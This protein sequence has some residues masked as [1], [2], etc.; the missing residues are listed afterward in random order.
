MGPLEYAVFITTS[1]LRL[2]AAGW[3]LDVIF[4]GNFEVGFRT[5]WQA[6]ALYVLAEFAI[7]VLHNYVRYR[8]I[9]VQSQLRRAAKEV[10]ERELREARLQQLQAQRQASE[11]YFDS[12]DM[13]L[14][15]G[16]KT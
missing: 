7:T 11:K 5:I 14:G 13:V 2:W 12:R 16:S 9:L 10:R 3:V 6:F 4:L 8:V 1:I 15:H